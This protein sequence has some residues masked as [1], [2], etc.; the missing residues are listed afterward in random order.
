M[1]FLIKVC[2]SWYYGIRHIILCPVLSIFHP[3]FLN[4]RRNERS[5]SIGLKSPTINPILPNITEA[6]KLSNIIPMLIPTITQHVVIIIQYGVSQ[7][8]L[9]TSSFL[10]FSALITV[11]MICPCWLKPFLTT[12]ILAPNL[13]RF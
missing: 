7:F 3:H 8:I 6:I 10:F 12:F 4:Y 13:I 5:I 11:A 1:L 9:F 2:F